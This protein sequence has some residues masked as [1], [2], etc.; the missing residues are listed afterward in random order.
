LSRL[1][2]APGEVDSALVK[3]NASE[4]GAV[5]YKLTDWL[6]LVAEYTHTGSKLHGGTSTSSD[7][8]A[9]GSFLFFGAQ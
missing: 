6:S 2:L 9:P 3:N 8:M 5:R 4:V 1:D 7:S